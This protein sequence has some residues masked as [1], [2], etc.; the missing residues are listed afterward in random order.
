MLIAGTS[1]FLNNENKASELKS[2]TPKTITPALVKKSTLVRTSLFVPY[3]SISQNKADFENYNQLLYFGIIPTTTGINTGDI[4]YQRLPTFIEQAGEKQERILVLR[5]LDS[6]VNDAIL[7][8]S[9]KQKTIINETVS[10]AKRNGFNGIALD[11]ELSALPFNSLVQ[12]IS[13]LNANFYRTTKKEGLTFSIVI[14]GDT[15]YRVRPFD[16]KTLAKSADN[17]MIMAY[18]LS[19]AGGNP[20]PNFPLSGKDKYG[21][22]YTLLMDNFLS[23]V[24]PQKL[25]VIFGLFGYDWQVDNKNISQ[26]IGKALSYSEIK[27]TIL[28]NCRA[29]QC[30]ITR[31]PLSKETMVTY[32]ADDKTKHVV[33]YEDMESLSAKQNYLKTR[34]IT[35]F[36]YW[37]YS[38]F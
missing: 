19:K 21:Y 6:N 10:L 3:W 29:L 38:Y 9:G 17:I 30:S 4:G 24:P 36:S 11:L 27:Q 8:D 12:Q 16:V 33:W 15:F 25:V 5:M 37:A 13:S 7:K 20:G 28:D 18:D 14:Y 31:D 23:E 2:V 32:I 1:F 22:D 26:K 34:G 35:N